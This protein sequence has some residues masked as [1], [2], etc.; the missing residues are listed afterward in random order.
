M[1]SSIRDALSVSS[2]G[3]RL[4]AQVKEYHRT[5]VERKEAIAKRIRSLK[6]LVHDTFVSYPKE[7][8]RRVRFDV[9]QASKERVRELGVEGGPEY[10]K[11]VMALQ[12]AQRSKKEYFEA[13]DIFLP[14]EHDFA[15]ESSDG[16]S[17]R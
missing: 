12:F 17:R 14:S 7:H 10:S 16:V 6:Q 5:E 4:V 1:S 3:Q 8:G 11:A 15:Y 9:Y 2:N 13:M